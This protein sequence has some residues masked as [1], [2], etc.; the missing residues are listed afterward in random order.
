MI[1]RSLHLAAQ[2]AWSAT[3]GRG[4]RTLAVTGSEPDAG[5]A[6]AA[7]AIAS[8]GAAF[9][10]RV[11]LVRAFHSDPGQPSARLETDAQS[12]IAAARPAGDLLWQLDVPTRTAMHALLNDGQHLP[13]VIATWLAHFDAIV[14]DCPP[15]EAEQPPIY[16]P[17]TAS[18][19]DAVLL[20]T[21][22]GTSP[23][24]A[25]DEVLK[26]LG[27]SGAI[28]SALVLNDRENPTLAQEMIREARRFA[29]L[30]PGLVRWI[31]RRIGGWTALNTHR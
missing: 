3:L 9:G 31:E 4:A 22:P 7:F 5:T 17:L 16:T 21:L 30:A 24:A 29:R 11:L 13:S 26:W 15:F 28:L 14:F 19:A 18:A 25:M 12:V 1:S 2:R 20:V 10:K 8:A 23:R 6:E 27:E